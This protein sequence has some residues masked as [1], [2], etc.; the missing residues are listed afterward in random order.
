[1]GDMS[2]EG[3]IGGFVFAC[4]TGSVKQK[5]YG[6]TEQLPAILFQV[7]QEIEGQG[8]VC[9]ELYVDTHSVNLSQAAEEVAAMFRVK[10]IPV[11]AGTP[12]E[13]AYAE[14]AVRTIGEMSRVQMAG[15]KHLPSSCWGLSD[16]HAGNIHDYLPQKRTGVSPFEFRHKRAPDLDVFFVH[17]FG[18]PCQYAPI[19]GADHKR[20]KKTEWGW[21]V[22]VQ[23]P[24]VLI[25]RPED[26]KVIS[27]SRHKVHCHE[28]AYAKY[29]PSKGGNPLENFAVPKIDL[30]KIRAKKTCKQ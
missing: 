28:E 18:C 20:A 6:T 16:I 10:I 1:M 11:S 8:Y 12:Q 2:F 24:M 14:S 19:T 5:L 3:A 27:V 15:A 17:V 7:L 29:D 13:M 9:R 22:G 21:Y 4:P 30:D 26:D 23:W 25:L